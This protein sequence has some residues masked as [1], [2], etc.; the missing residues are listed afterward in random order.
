ML[1]MQ[2]NTG[3]MK[4]A[5]TLGIVFALPGIAALLEFYGLA[6]HMYYALGGWPQGIGTAGFPKVLLVHATL[7]AQ[8]FWIMLFASFFIA[9]AGIMISLFRERWR[10]L[11][12]YFAEFALVYFLSVLLMQLAPEPFLSWWMD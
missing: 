7:A 4:R 3:A 8:T 6:I 11:L 9:P 1:A 2:S 10:Y 12:P 5:Y